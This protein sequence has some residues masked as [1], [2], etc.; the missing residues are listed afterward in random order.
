MAPPHV[1]IILALRGLIAEIPPALD[2]LLGRSP[3]DAELQAPARDEIGSTGVFG[4][5]ERVL[6]AHVDHSGSDLDAAG[7]RTNR[8]QQW[9]RRSKLAGEMVDPEI[10]P[11]R[12]QL[13]GGNG[14]INGL[15]QRIRGR[16]G[17]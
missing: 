12:A 6:V 16:A 3:A 8:C 15:Q 5:V 11:V 10:R 1:G 4:H 17:L 2:D 9:K 13:F 7:F 14:K